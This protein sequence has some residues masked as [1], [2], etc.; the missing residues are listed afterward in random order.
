[1]N[2][3]QE[4]NTST[5]LTMKNT[6]DQ[7]LILAL[8][9]E[10]MV[11]NCASGASSRAYLSQIDMKTTRSTSRFLSSD[12]AA[13]EGSYVEK[14]P[15]EVITATV[16][17]LST[18]CGADW[19]STINGVVEAKVRMFRA[20]RHQP[21]KLHYIMLILPD[22]YSGNIPSLYV[23]HEFGN[24]NRLKEILADPGKFHTEF[25]S[26]EAIDRSGNAGNMLRMSQLILG[27]RPTPWEELH[28][29]A[30]KLSDGASEKPSWLQRLVARLLKK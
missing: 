29:K 30:S 10:M 20:G 17:A 18:I 19:D 11:I 4:E 13:L 23:I 3:D 26:G 5:T 25:A 14:R 6:R 7:G 22:L 21:W 15:V 2:T 28:S 8:V 24:S 12:T 27:D 16:R 1:M 9:S